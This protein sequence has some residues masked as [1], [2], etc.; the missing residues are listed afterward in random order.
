MTHNP[1][2]IKADVITLLSSIVEKT[3]SMLENE[4]ITELEFFTNEEAIE[5]GWQFFTNFAY[6]TYRSCDD[7]ISVYVRKIAK[8]N[9]K[10]MIYVFDEMAGC[11]T[12]PYSII[13]QVL[14]PYDIK[15]AVRLYNMVYNRINDTCYPIELNK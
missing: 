6:W 3:I 11:E 5:N 15:F 8:I 1:A 13:E 2:T 7:T 14:K 4:N 12:K 9:G 10:W